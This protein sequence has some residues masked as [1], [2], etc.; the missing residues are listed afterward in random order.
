MDVDCF[1]QGLFAGA[2]S[3]VF[4]LTKLDLLNRM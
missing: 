4:Q 3:T 1:Q 2:L